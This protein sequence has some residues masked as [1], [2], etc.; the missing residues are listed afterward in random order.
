MTGEEREGGDCLRRMSINHT[1]TSSWVSRK[2][3]AGI[4]E[5]SISKI[6]NCSELQTKLGYI[7]KL[8]KQIDNRVNTRIWLD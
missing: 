4:E 5:K 2:D 7:Q 8:T 1:A 3:V 6:Y